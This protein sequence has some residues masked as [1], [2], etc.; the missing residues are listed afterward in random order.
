MHNDSMPI[1]IKYNAK[2][3]QLVVLICSSRRAAEVLALSG[4]IILCRY[5]E[6]FGDQKMVFAINS[7]RRSILKKQIGPSASK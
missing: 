3:V 2:F 6:R 1:F 7:D 4:F 5:M